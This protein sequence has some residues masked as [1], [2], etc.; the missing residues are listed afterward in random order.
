MCPI[1]APTNC[2]FNDNN[3]LEESIYFNKKCFE[4]NICTFKCKDNG[5]EDCKKVIYLELPSTHPSF[6]EYERVCVQKKK[7]DIKSALKTSFKT[8]FNTFKLYTKFFFKGKV[9]MKG[10]LN[11]ISRFK[12]LSKRLRSKQE[13]IKRFFPKVTRLCSQELS[14]IPPK[15]QFQQLFE[16]SV[17]QDRKLVKVVEIST[18]RFINRAVKILKKNCDCSE[19][20]TISEQDQDRG[21]DI[22]ENKC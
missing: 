22:C 11:F 14:H 20:M 9:N 12:R 15:V 8:T 16:M 18:K 19:F 3:V 17:P 4:K 13:E 10:I 1:A 5:Y 21:E 6:S 7:E 2:N